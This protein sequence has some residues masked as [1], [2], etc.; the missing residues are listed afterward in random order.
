MMH[1]VIRRRFKRAAERNEET[2]GK[3]TTFPDFVIID[4]GKGQLN[5]AL[6]AMEETGLNVPMAGLAKE[7]EEIFSLGNRSRSCCLA[8][9]RRFIWSSACATKHIVSRLHST[10]KTI[11]TNLHIDASTRSR[12]RTQEEEGR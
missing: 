5:A 7:N 8:I 4:G 11:E 10:G 2:E 3:W 12:D 9:L 1:E 6:A